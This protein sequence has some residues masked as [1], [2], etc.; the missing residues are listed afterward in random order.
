VTRE[1]WDEELP[2]GRWLDAVAAPQPLPAGGRVASIS[3]AFAAALVE[4]IAR[5]VL[6]SPSRAPLHADAELVVERAQ[7]LRPYVLDIGEA[8]DRAY[9]A[10]LAARR[11]A[12]Q[13][14]SPSLTDAELS[15]A[16]TQLH[17]IEQCAEVAALARRLA[18][19][20]PQT[21]R[22]DLA[23]ASHLA[24]AGARSA[25]G[26]LLSDLENLGDTVA[27]DTVRH[28]AAAALERV[29]APADEN[30]AARDERRAT[31]ALP[32]PEGGRA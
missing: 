21:L 28:A 8:D 27:A 24:L 20:L 18:A 15:A 17:L 4:K 31:D 22:A 32:P 10:I 26:N 6:R 5:I 3:L 11:G 9:A 19:G 16:R 29:T 14:P 1:R 2:L 13:A 23:T 7:A 12:G 30:R 25:H